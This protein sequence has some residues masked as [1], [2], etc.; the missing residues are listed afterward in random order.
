[1]PSRITAAEQRAHAANAA[2]LNVARD[3]AMQSMI[4]GALEQAEARARADAA[5]NDATR[6][7]VAQVAALSPGDIQVP[8][9]YQL[10]STDDLNT[11]GNALEK[12]GRRQGIEKA[13]ERHNEVMATKRPLY[14]T[15]R[16]RDQSYGQEGVPIREAFWNAPLGGYVRAVAEN[17]NFSPEHAQ[18]AERTAAGLLAT[19]VGLGGIGLA[20]NNLQ[21]GQ[22]ADTLPMNNTY[23]Y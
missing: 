8:E 19:G 18:I 3:V 20:L 4:E 22:T 21:G 17:M 14:E 23:V 12:R 15:G 11:I 5:G 13:A 1:M 2:S 10:L 16:Y 9:G 6:A 7:A